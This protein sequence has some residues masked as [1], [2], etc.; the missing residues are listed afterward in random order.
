MLSSILQG[1]TFITVQDSLKVV[2]S[3]G[4]KMSSM[5]SCYSRVTSYLGAEFS[6]LVH[7]AQIMNSQVTTEPSLR[8]V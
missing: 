4:K 6:S 3:E 8:K 7:K 5:M 1:F 2:L